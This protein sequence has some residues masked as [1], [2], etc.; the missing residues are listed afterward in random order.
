MI[1][2]K[3]KLALFVRFQKEFQIRKLF[4]KRDFFFEAVLLLGI[5]DEVARDF[6]ME[7]EIHFAFFGKDEG[8]G[9]QKVS[10]VGDWLEIL[11]GL[12]NYNLLNLFNRV[13]YACS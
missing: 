11:I 8:A 2:R 3:E 10:V 1:H 9:R 5:V 7:K 4:E 6:G 12:L 13:K